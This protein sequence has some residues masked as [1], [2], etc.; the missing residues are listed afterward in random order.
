MRIMFIGSIPEHIPGVNQE[1]LPEHQPL[2]TAAHDLGHAVAEAGHR[3]LIGST[4]PRTIDACVVAGVAD[5]CRQH[6]DRFAHIEVHRP[7]DEPPNLLRDLPNLHFLPYP[8]HADPS[9]PHKWVVAHARAADEADVIVA[10]AGAISTRLVGHLAADR[11][12]SLIAIPCFGGAAEELYQFLRYHYGGV[13][14]G[15]LPA[16]A[17]LSGWD[18]DTPGNVVRLAEALF[19]EHQRQAPHT[20]F[21]SY[22]WADCAAADHIETLLRREHRPILRD[23]ADLQAGKPLSKSVQA[24]IEECDTFI[25]LWSP[26]YAQ[27]SWCPQEVEYAINLRHTGRKPKRLVLLAL[28]DHPRPLRLADQ[29]YELATSRR[30]RELAILHL[31]RAEE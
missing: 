16:V 17:L 2:L 3:I 24:L 30:D 5:F 31:V 22:S 28:E 25:A 26:R 4:S 8:H 21:I 11:G 13:K 9:S 27:S 18:N 6:P 23:E 20:Y 15:E 12:K 7:E 1:I 19:R 14:V 10:M 29:L